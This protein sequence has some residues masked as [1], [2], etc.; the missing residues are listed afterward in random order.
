ML[1]HV[2]FA[3]NLDAIAVTGLRPGQ[4]KNFW[5]YLYYARNTRNSTF[6]STYETLDCWFQKLQIAG[7]DRYKQNAVAE[8][9]FPVA[10]RLHDDAVERILEDLELDRE[11]DR[12][13]PDGESFFCAMTISPHELD[14]WDGDEWRPIRRVM[15]DTMIKK[16]RR[17]STHQTVQ[18]YDYLELDAHTFQPRVA[19]RLR[20]SIE[21]L[22][23]ELTSEQSAYQTCDASLQLCLQTCR[24][25]TTLPTNP[26]STV[27][28]SVPAPVDR[29]MRPK[30][31]QRKQTVDG[32]F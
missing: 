23:A 9:A 29:P 15:S 14:V 4:G 17:R 1:Y 31:V 8:G 19:T 2:T 21:R 32:L 6:F 22:Q 16:A 24:K 5:N 7:Q 13:C 11:G 26:P 27:P 20:S 25:R 30:M 18:G 12:D 28:R 3:R 10:L